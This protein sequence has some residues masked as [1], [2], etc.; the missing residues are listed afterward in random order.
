M[1]KQDAAAETLYKEL[2][3]ELKATALQNPSSGAVVPTT[4]DHL[5]RLKEKQQGVHKKKVTE[6]LFF[7][8]LGHHVAHLGASCPSS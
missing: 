5:R 8:L 1:P 4:E 3:E 7:A 6:A 2:L